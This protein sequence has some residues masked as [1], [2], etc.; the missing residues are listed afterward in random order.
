MKNTWDVIPDIHADIERLEATL[1]AREPGVPIAFLGDII[2]AGGATRVSDDVAVLTRVRDL[3]DT[4]KAVAV[5]GNHE[6]N[7]ILYHTV[8]AD[9]VPL[10][11]RSEKNRAQ[12]RS[13]VQQL[14]TAT[15]QAHEW[16][17]WFLNLPLW[18]DLDG[19]RLVHACWSQPD[20]D[21]IAERRPDGRI[22][23]ADLPEIATEE[24]PFARAVKNLVTGPEVRLEPSAHPG[25][26]DAGG[27]R[28]NH[29]RIAWWRS[30]T[31]TWR[32]AALSVPRPEELPAGDVPSSREVAFYPQDAPPV[33]VGHYKMTGESRIESDNAA[34]LDYP[35]STCVYRWRGESALTEENL[36]RIEPTQGLVSVNA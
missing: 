5:M 21:L 23:R 13:F 9:R 31:R 14:G 12:D 17:D 15:P 32:D 29:V 1:Q 26:H 19:L 11:E 2:D 27:H 36:V 4:G 3:V 16:I 33:I 28:R 6:L 34:C 35:Q 10:R 8:G 18:R 30:G 20:I 25:F 22:T 24:T 7:A